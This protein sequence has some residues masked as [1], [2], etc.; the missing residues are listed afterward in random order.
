V[1][2]ALVL[3]D[4][5]GEL[6]VDTKEVIISLIFS[7]ESLRDIE[8]MSQLYYTERLEELDDEGYFAARIIVKTTHSNFMIENKV[9][10]VL[11]NAMIHRG[12]YVRI[13]V[14]YEGDR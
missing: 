9:R 5:L 3:A 4:M 11:L 2:R 12:Q 8:A 1:T 14:Y 7:F 10:D 13:L 6:Q